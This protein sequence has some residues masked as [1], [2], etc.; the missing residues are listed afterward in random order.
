[1]QNKWRSQAGFS[2]IE[3]LIAVV[4]L[5]VGLLG[6]AQ[7]QITA[8]QANSKSESLMAATALAQQVL[9]EM[10]AL[11]EGDPLFDGALNQYVDWGV[12]QINVPGAGAYD[13]EYRLEQTT[14][15]VAGVLRVLIRVS[16]VSA[17][18]GVFGRR[19]VVL[20]SLKRTV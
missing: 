10:V 16:P 1:M 17:N 4:I 11:P 13:V 20:T 9:E 7:L 18:R 6:L 19:A 14:P 3:M 12:G 2:M 5:A 8:I 15:V